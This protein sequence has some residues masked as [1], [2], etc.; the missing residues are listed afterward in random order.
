MQIAF[1]PIRQPIPKV[2]S[3]SL[4]LVLSNMPPFANWPSGG[5]RKGNNSSQQAR[6]TRTQPQKRKRRRE[7]RQSKH[8]KTPSLSSQNNVAGL[9]PAPGTPPGPR[10]M[11]TP[12]SQV[13]PRV[14]GIPPVPRYT[15]GSQVHPRVSGTPPGLTYTS[16]SQV[17]VALHVLGIFEGT[18]NL[19]DPRYTPESQVHLRVSLTPLGLRYTSC[20][21]FWL[22]LKIPASLRVPGTPPDV[23]YTSGSQVLW[24]GGGLGLGLVWGTQSP[25]R[26]A[27]T[28]S[29]ILEKLLHTVFPL[30]LSLASSR[31][32]SCFG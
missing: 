32:S 21:M 30:L 27:P 29:R 18:C 10:Y 7:T 8:Q 20:F 19:P 2:W 25:R 26:A 12:G 23:K 3:K 13:H 22:Y 4:L 11:Y 15:P 31:F 1:L 28:D 14:P 9:K 24:W 16:G 6:N 5:G 17:H